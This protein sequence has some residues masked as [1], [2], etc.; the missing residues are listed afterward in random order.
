MRSRTPFTVKIRCIELINNGNSITDIATLFDLSRKTIYK[1]LNRY[2]KH[3]L[4]GLAD[5]STRPRC[6]P[7]ALSDLHVQQIVSLRVK[8]KIGPAR[9]ALRLGLSH[10]SVYRTLCRQGLQYLNPKRPKKKPRRYEKTYPGELW[11]L[12]TKTLVPLR[13][14]YPK[15]HQ[16]AILDDYSREAFCRIYPA[17]TTGAATDFLQL[18]LKYYNYPV[19]AVLTDNAFCFSMRYANYSDR[20]TLFSR[21]CQQLG[22]RHYL[23]RPYH[24]E[25]NGKVERFFRTVNDECFSRLHLRNSGHRSQVLDDFVHYYNFN[26]PHLSLKGLTPVQ[27]RTNYFNSVTDVLE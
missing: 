25:T 17:A 1:W 14:G 7:E 8:E 5:H 18:A 2:Q 20:L 26:R 4:K 3:G 21:T 9:I 15:E 16:F 19:K 27:R 10:S 12:D 24:P 23:L 13:R 6:S 11:H 22:I